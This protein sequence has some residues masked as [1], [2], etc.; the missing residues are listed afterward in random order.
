MKRSQ[1][2]AKGLSFR[3]YAIDLGQKA[4]LRER[5]RFRQSRRCANANAFPMLEFLNRV[6]SA[7][8]FG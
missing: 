4:T 3:A 2:V 7:S 5:S 6:L 8:I 1:S